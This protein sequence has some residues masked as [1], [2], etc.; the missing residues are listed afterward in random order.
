V[1]FFCSTSLICFASFA[2]QPWAEQAPVQQP[3][4]LPSLSEVDL[5]WFQGKRNG[6]QQQLNEPAAAADVCLEAG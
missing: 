4:Y 6:E 3:Q 5:G 2:L 1:C